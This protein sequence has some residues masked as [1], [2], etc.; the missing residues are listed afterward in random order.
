MGR[1]GP[2]CAANVNV[3]H[4]VTPFVKCVV[5]KVFVKCV[6]LASNVCL[7]VLGNFANGGYYLQQA[8]AAHHLV[9]ARS[10]KQIVNWGRNN[11]PRIAVYLCC[12]G[13]AVLWCVCHFV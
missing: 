10:S 9:A 1:Y 13:A 7:A 2:W 5:L 8:C 11:N 3:L 12:N 4:G 6:V